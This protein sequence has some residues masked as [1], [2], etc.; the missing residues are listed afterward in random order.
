MIEVGGNVR[1]EV[2]ESA[3]DKML[4]VQ[5]QPIAWR[6]ESMDIRR[7]RS[8]SI[9]FICEIFEIGGKFGSWVQVQAMLV[10]IKV[11]TSL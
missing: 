3:R 2:R 7:M 6:G 8:G 1:R 9:F 10:M 11:K 5:R 4:V